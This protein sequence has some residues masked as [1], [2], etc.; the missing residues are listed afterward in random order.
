MVSGLSIRLHGLTA[1]ALSQQLMAHLKPLG[2]DEWAV[3]EPDDGQGQL[4]VRL[5]S[6]AFARWCP[7]HDTLHATQRHPAPF[8]SLEQAV[9][10]ELWLAWLASPIALSFESWADV[11]SAER[12]RCLLSHNARR[13]SM[14]FHTEEATRPP[15]HW[16][17]HEDTGFTLLPNQDLVEALILATQPEISGQ[18]YAFSC[19]RATEYVVVLSIA[20]ELK[21]HHPRLYEALQNH[22]RQKAI[23]SEDFHATFLVE[24]GS[25]QQP[26]PMHWYVP[27]DRVWFKNPHLP[28]TD[29]TGY[30]GSWVVY[31]G[32]GLFCNFWQH[33]KPYTLEHKCVEI[34]HWRDGLF[35]D[36]QGEAQINEDRVNALTDQSL[37]D[38]EAKARILSLM[39]RFRDPMGVYAQGGCMDATREVPLKLL[40]EHCQ[41]NLPAL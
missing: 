4:R 13:T 18:V 28:S 40:P 2:L 1:Q 10:W 14:D 37:A 16:T 8:P 5:A 30:E 36:A 21:A 20:Q 12:V 11:M 15:A 33:T 26:L 3:C 7:D 22:W 27:G 29:A 39:Q 17:Y 25:V 24:L 19:Y 38:P 23:M 31:L 35:I 41:V 32:Q 9:R 6:E 34:F